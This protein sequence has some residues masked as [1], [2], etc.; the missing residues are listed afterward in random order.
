MSNDP[1]FPP[2]SHLFLKANVE[3][4]DAES[5]PGFPAINAVPTFHVI[6]AGKIKSLSGANEAAL[7]SAIKA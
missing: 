3:E 4:V 1:A 7:L 2:T 5:L 6:K